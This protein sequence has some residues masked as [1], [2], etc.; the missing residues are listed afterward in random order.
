MHR[1]SESN[2]LSFATR[3]QPAAL[4]QVRLQTRR[5]LFQKSMQLGGFEEFRIRYGSRIGAE[6]EILEQRSIPKL[7]RGI[8]PCSLRAKFVQ[9]LCVQRNPI[10]KDSATC[11]PVPAYQQSEQTRFARAGWAHYG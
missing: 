1:A 7:H 9:D 11:R 2:A 5:Q 10:Y 8:N 3:D 6:E 4:S